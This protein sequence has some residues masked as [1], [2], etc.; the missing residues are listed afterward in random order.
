MIMQKPHTQS[1]RFLLSIA[2]LCLL[3]QPALAG[4]MRP[5]PGS[6]LSRTAPSIWLEE[7]NKPCTRFIE[8]DS[9]DLF[10]CSGEVCSSD[11]DTCN[12]WIQCDQ[13]RYDCP[14]DP[15]GR[16]IEWGCCGPSKG[17]WIYQT[18]ECPDEPWVSTGQYVCNGPCNIS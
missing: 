5:A 17:K 4:D 16:W 18:R 10:Y 13:A 8:C 15:E 14:G 7:E 11:P 3:A 12:G 2:V 1:I 9:G 6:D